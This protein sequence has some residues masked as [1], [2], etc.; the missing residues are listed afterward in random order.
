MARKEMINDS[1]KSRAD[2]DTNEQET[3]FRDA[4]SS[5]DN[6]NN[7]ERLENYRARSDKDYRSNLGHVLTKVEEAVDKGNI[8]CEEDQDRL[9]EEHLEW[10]VY[11]A[12]NDAFDRP[13]LLLVLRVYRRFRGIGPTYFLRL[14]K[15][16]SGDVRHQ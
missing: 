10:S 15:H 6:V 12:T 13:V 8:N 14:R 9:H 2:T 16:L 7:R 11:C 3:V 5:S 4:E 1:P